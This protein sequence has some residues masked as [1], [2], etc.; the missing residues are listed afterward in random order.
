MS[1]GNFEL[2]EVFPSVKLPR[3]AC[4]G[5]LKYS[6][7]KDDFNEIPDFKKLKPTQTGIADSTFN[8]NKLGDS[9]Y[10]C[11]LEGYFEAKNDGHYIFAVN[12][13]NKNRFYI[14]GKLIIDNNENESPDDYKSY[15]LPLEKGFYAVRIEYLQPK[16]GNGLNLIYVEPGTRNGGIIPLKLLYNN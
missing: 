2:G 4:Q 13:N 10:T 6:V 15:I 14:N 3:K 16:G 1:R 12:K 9:G 7:Y 5:G 11:V 8:L